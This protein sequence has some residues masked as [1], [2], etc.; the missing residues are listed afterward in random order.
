MSEAEDRGD[1]ALNDT[2]SDIVD[3]KKEEEVIVDPKKEEE[4]I[5]DP[6]KEEE[7]DPKAALTI[8]KKVFDER[9]AKARDREA[10]AI[11]RAEEAEA[12]IQAKETTVD[13]DKLSKALD[14]AEEALEKAVADGN[15]DRK[16][17]LRKEIRELNQTL[18]DSRAEAHAMRGTALAVEQVRYDAAVDRM[19][20]EH[21]ELNPDNEDTY[22][23]EIVAEITELKEA[24][25]AK[26]HASSEALKKAVKL[27]YRTAVTKELEGKDE[28]TAEKAARIASERKEAAA[29]KG[30]D[31]KKAQPTD[32]KKVGLDSDKAGAKLT[33][34]DV[35]K[36]S[37]KE[38]DDLSDADKKRFRGD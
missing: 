6:K 5:V 12:K 29:L 33:A 15:V 30:L 14:E 13:V 2:T 36:M 7:K 32:S 9:I 35:A 38:F 20:I 37:D 25:E 22:D 17:A 34:A 27:V 18:A 16:L 23:T 4:V 11:K 10:A 1:I 24:F 19:E 31:A 3:P 8:P 26:G 28:T 21:P